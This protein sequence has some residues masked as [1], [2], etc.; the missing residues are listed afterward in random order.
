MTLI[1]RLAQQIGTEPDWT[2]ASGTMLRFE[3]AAR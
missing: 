2:S 1:E 3:F